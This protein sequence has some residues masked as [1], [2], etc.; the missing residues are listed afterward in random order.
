MKGLPILIGALVASAISPAALEARVLETAPIV[1]FQEDN[2]T[3]LGHLFYKDGEYYDTKEDSLRAQQSFLHSM[4]LL[5][6]TAN[7]TLDYAAAAYQ[8]GSAHIVSGVNWTDLKSDFNFIDAISY[9][10]SARPYFE[11]HVSKNPGDKNILEVLASLNFYLARCYFDI[12][13]FENGVKAA[14]ESLKYMN[15]EAAIQRIVRIIRWHPERLESIKKQIKPAVDDKTF[16]SILQGLDSYPK[17][18]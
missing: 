16:T 1:R 13:D 14:I 9:L 12:R 7:E 3:Y 17:D 5:R 2:R 10:T 18:Q 8:L 15:D 6:S 4:M 11:H